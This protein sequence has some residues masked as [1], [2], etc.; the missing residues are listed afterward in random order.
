MVET[1]D[2]VILTSDTPAEDILRPQ[3]SSL[4]PVEPPT[5]LP[6][7]GVPTGQETKLV[8]SDA[9]RFRSRSKYRGWA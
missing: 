3:R 4:P 8:G 7:M 9:T 2:Q 1:A 6:V 5:K